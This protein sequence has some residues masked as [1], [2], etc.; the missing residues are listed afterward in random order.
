MLSQGA[1]SMLIPVQHANF[2]V[3]GIRMILPV[4]SRGPKN[5]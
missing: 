1:Q 3:G 4:T 2:E 5:R